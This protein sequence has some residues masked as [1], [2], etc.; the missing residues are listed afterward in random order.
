MRR[1]EFTYYDTV[2]DS[3]NS[4]GGTCMRI[5]VWNYDRPIIGV[6][7]SGDRLAHIWNVVVFDLFLCR[8]NCEL[9]IT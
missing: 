5:Q 3:K 4:D 9:N 7:H 6:F 2:F 1:G 8:R